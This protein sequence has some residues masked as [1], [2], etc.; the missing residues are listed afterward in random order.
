MHWDAVTIGSIASVGVA[1]VIIVFLAFRVSAL[2]KSDAEKH[3]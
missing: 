2:M 1:V 3:K